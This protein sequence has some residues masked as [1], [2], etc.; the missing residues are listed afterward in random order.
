M[1]TEKTH[2]I[3]FSKANV[4]EREGG[5]AVTI[6]GTTRFLKTSQI[7]SLTFQGASVHVTL[8]RSDF[9]RLTARPKTSDAPAPRHAMT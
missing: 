6:Y 8:S 7:V 4:R 3:E 9:H 5:Y 2:T 1:T